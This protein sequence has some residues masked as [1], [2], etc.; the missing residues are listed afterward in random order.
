MVIVFSFTSV[1]LYLQEIIP[2]ENWIGGCVDPKAR[3]D[4]VEKRI[5]CF[6][7]Q[8]SNPGQQVIRYID[9]VVPTLSKGNNI[10]LSNCSCKSKSKAIPVTG[11]GCLYSCKI[12]RIPHCLDNRL[13]DGGEVVS[14]THRPLLYSPETL[15]LCFWPHLC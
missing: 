5:I 1:P 15:F 14:S 12:L 8:E 2:N 9:A 4:A 11:R 13:T 10:I 3:L 6:F 7:C